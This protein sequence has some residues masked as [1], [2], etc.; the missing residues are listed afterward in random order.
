[1]PKITAI[2]TVDNPFD[3]IDEFKKW[4]NFDSQKG[5]FTCA[6]LARLSNTSIDL[7]PKDYEI[8]RESAID[9]IVQLNPV[10]YKKV[11]KTA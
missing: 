4:Y 1:M 7:S 11:V 8:E 2:S 10:L 6:L 5:Y 3:P 9:S